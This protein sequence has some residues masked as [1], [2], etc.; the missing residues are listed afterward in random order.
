MAIGTGI[1]TMHFIAML[2]FD[3]TGPTCTMTSR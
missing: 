2:G 3:V 1:W